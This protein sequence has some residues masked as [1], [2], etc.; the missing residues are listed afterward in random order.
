MRTQHWP[1][2]HWAL[3]A[4]A[5]PNAAPWPAGAREALVRALLVEARSDGALTQDGRSTPTAARLEGLLAALARP[6]WSPRLAA[7]A[8]LIPQP[9]KLL[10]ARVQAEAESAIAL[11]LPFLLRLQRPDG[12][13]PLGG[14]GSTAGMHRIDYTQHALSAFAGALAQ[15][16]CL[17][18]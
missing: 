3:I 1:P 17:K 13:L 16:R 18:N 12:S 15:G 10:Q 4:A 6:E 5:E 8:T 9:Q 2:D 7:N 14:S 11:G